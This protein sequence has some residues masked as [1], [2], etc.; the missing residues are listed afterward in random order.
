MDASRVQYVR[1]FLRLLLL[2]VA[3]VA[4]LVVPVVASAQTVEIDGEVLTDAGA[5]NLSGVANI[6]VR[7]I[8]QDTENAAIGF[9]DHLGNYNISNLVPGSYKLEF[10][11]PECPGGGNLNYAP[12]YWP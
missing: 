8:N 7:A 11:T 12:A 9:T 1:P 5:E 4:A 3:L 6:C 2:I 10:N